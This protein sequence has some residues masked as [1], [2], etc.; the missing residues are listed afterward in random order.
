MILRA[1]VFCFFI[2]LHPNYVERNEIL[3]SN[4]KSTECKHRYFL[5]TENYQAIILPVV[6]VI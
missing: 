3:L 1:K 4:Q 5:K 2:L 6:T